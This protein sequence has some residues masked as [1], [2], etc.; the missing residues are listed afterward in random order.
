MEGV[1]LFSFLGLG[2]TVRRAFVRLDAVD[3]GNES[4]GWALIVPGLQKR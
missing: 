1:L 3:R 2:L 4:L